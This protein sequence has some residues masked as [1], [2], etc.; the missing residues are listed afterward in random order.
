MIRQQN[1]LKLGLLIIFALL[2]IAALIGAY[3]GHYFTKTR[4]G[5]LRHM[6]YLN[7]K[8]EKMLPLDIIKWFVVILILIITII[9]LISLLR[10]SNNNIGMLLKMIST[11]LGIFTLYFIVFK[12]A[13]INRAY[14]IISLCLVLGTV[15]QNVMCKIFEK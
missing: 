8:W 3:A 5:M 4:M 13:K 15:F 7:G 6:I 1:K 14:Y 9:S 12:S 10:R 11:A 2:E